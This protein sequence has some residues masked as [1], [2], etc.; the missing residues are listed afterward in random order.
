MEQEE[1]QSTTSKPAKKQRKEIKTW[2]KWTMI[3]I[4]WIGIM[5]PFIAIYYMLN[6]V[7]D[8]TLPGFEELENPQSNLASRVFS[9]D[10]VEL[11]KYYK[12]N[13]TNAKYHE[14]SP[15]LINALVATEDARY[16]SHSGVDARGLGRAIY[17]Q[18]VGEDGGGASTISQ[19]LAKLL[20]TKVAKDK[21]ER[22]KQKFGENILAVR[23]E[24]AYTKEEII[25]MYFNKFD[26]LNNAVG[27]NSASRVYFN[28]KPIDL[29]V[30]EAAMLVGMAKN[31]SLFNPLR[32]P[33]DV[34]KRR[35]V[36][37]S[38]M[39][40]ANFLTETEYDS[41]RQ[42]PIGL[43]YTRV[44]HQ[45]GL[46]P[47]FRESLRAEVSKILA[48]KDA[49]GNY[50]IVD[51]DGNP[52]DIYADGLKIYTT[53]D[54]RMQEY[55]EWAV[56]E[57]LKYYLQGAFFKNNAKWKNPPFSNDL[58]EAEIDTL[59][60]RAMRRSQMYK[61]LTGKVCGYCERPEK[62]ISLQDDHYTCSYCQHQT[63]VH[64]KDQ[65]MAKFNEARPMRIF[66]WQSPDYEK[67][68][69]MTAI[70]SI[71]YYKSL[72]RASMVSINPHNGHVKAWVGGPYFKHFKFDMVKQGRRQ[73]GSTF[74]PFIYGTALE[75]GVVTP[76]DEI[77]DAEHCIEV[78]YNKYR[79]KMWCPSNSGAKFTYAPMPIPFALASSMNNITAK[80][81]KMGGPG[82]LNE[83]FDRVSQLGM[84]TSA[85]EPVPSMS[86]GVFDL[87]VYE[88]VGAMT[89]FVNNGIYIQPTYI[90]K[91]EDKHGNVIYEPEVYSKEVW[92][93]KT[94]YTVLELMK[95]VTTGTKHP[96]L[97]N[98]NG[99]PL[100]G[101]TAIRIRGKESEKRPYA[102]IKTPIAGKTG[103]TQ[104]QSDGWFMGLTPD[105][106]TGVWVG[107]EDRAVRFRSLQLGMGTN[108][109]LPMWAYYMKKVYADSTLDISQGDFTKPASIIID[110]LDCNQ[111]DN[112]MPGDIDFNGNDGLNIWDQEG[113]SDDVW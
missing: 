41:L 16:Y 51:A 98:K 63:P 92:T 106:V 13:R 74:K 33:E 26:F 21:M 59:M 99:R 34:L 4:M 28:K 14:L 11:G 57:H 85:F 43:N 69:V 72:L 32:K 23:L 6:K 68:T 35:E 91:I 38:Q 88:M 58:S 53:I 71:R 111:V 18:I 113:D 102:G 3:L 40:K 42:L 1:N 56:Q 31:P 5:S 109:A 17:G 77:L 8:G 15:N 62:F 110:P 61:I 105:L 87:S 93:E 79:E 46:A 47:Y 7:D 2:A 25:T 94:A 112:G 90:L 76:C 9:E 83:T 73:V 44:D 100:V 50:E 97:K 52:Y 37:L 81:V 20:F 36:V 48:R 67:D 70:D 89:S 107:A 78:P 84:D 82:F 29:E 30:Q 103:T 65:I 101:G 64:T 104:N 108:M 75:L 19:Q 12:E 54:S 10:G 49:D 39:V 27:I 80:I 22:L 96:T 45:T 66:D 60:S 24:K 86:L 95:K 55:A